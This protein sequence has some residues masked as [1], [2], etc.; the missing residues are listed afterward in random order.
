MKSASIKFTDNWIG[1]RTIRKLE[2]GKLLSYQRSVEVNNMEME[3][4]ISN[5]PFKYVLK[6]CI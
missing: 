2:T 6:L 1:Q 5:E 4:V 3:F